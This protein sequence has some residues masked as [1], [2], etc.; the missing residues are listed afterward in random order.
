MQ[1]HIYEP[2]SEAKWLEVLWFKIMGEYI[3]RGLTERKTPEV[4]WCQLTLAVAGKKEK[5]K[6]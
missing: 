5:V 6:R 4:L 3:Y 2:L 1:A